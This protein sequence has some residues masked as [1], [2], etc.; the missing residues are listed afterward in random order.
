MSALAALLT[1]RD[2]LSTAERE[3]WDAYLKHTSS[4]QQWPPFAET[5]RFRSYEVGFELAEAW[6][7]RVGMHRFLSMARGAA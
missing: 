3:G 4:R 6:A 1:D 5:E 2:A 7:G